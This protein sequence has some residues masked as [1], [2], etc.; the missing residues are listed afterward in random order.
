M[1]FRKKLSNDSE[2]SEVSKVCSPLQIWQQVNTEDTEGLTKI[3]FIN[4]ALLVHKR[5]QVKPEPVS[6]PEKQPVKPPIK[7]PEEVKAKPV[8]VIDPLEYTMVSGSRQFLDASIVDMKQV[9]KSMFSSYTVYV[10][11]TTVSP[12]PSDVCSQLSSAAIN[13]T[14]RTGLRDAIMTLKTCTWR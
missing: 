3:Q 7:L 12:F 1:E 13:R 2:L 5:A 4:A 9:S 10:I 11:E 6:L 8:K 14:K